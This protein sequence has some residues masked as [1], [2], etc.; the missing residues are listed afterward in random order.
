MSEPEE[1]AIKDLPPED[2]PFVRWAV[3]KGLVPSRKNERRAVVCNREKLQQ[4]LSFVSK[5]DGTTA[6]QFAAANKTAVESVEAI[7]R[8]GLLVKGKGRIQLA[9]SVFP[10]Y[11]LK[12]IRRYMPWLVTE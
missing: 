12:D 6:K 1:V 2:V 9:S 4:L 7:F 8:S 5:F 10:G 3:R 11:A